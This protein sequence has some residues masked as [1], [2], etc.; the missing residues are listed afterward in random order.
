MIRFVL[1]FFAY[2]GSLLATGAEPFSVEKEIPTLFMVADFSD[3]ALYE[4]EKAKRVS[5]DGCAARIESSV[6]IDDLANDVDRL[7]SE[8]NIG[9]VL[10]KGMWTPTGLA[11]RIRHLRSVARG[12]L[13]FAQDLEWGLSMRHFG[14]VEMPKALCMGAI[15]DDSLL[16]AWADML[17]KT[18]RDVGITCFLGPVADI[19]SNPKNPIIHDRS[20]GDDP[21]VVA[22]KVSVV[23]NALRRHGLI[24]CLKHFPGHGDTSQDSHSSLPVINKTYDQVAKSELIPFRS[25][26]EA[27]ADCV[28]TAHICLPQTLGGMTPASLSPFWCSSTLRNELG[29]QGVVMTDDLIMAGA[30]GSMT[31]AQTA[32]QAVQAGNDLCIVSFDVEKCIDAVIQAV[33]SGRLQRDDIDARAKRVRQ[34][35]ALATPREPSPTLSAQIQLHNLLY[36]KALTSVGEPV[37]FIPSSAILLQVGDAPLCPLMRDLVQAYPGADVESWRRRPRQDE[38]EGLL[39][40]LRAK[41][42]LGGKDSSSYFD[43]IFTSGRTVEDSEPCIHNQTLEVIVVLCDLERSPGCS[44]GITDELLNGVQKITDAG[45]RV[46]YVIFGSPYVLALLPKPVASALV[47]YERTPGSERAVFLALSG[48][49]EPTGVLPVKL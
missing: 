24:V 33:Q 4:K 47:A 35:Q 38:I 17:A 37:R 30:C 36:Q 22:H 10:F 46:R 31:Y 34:L 49:L 15:S 26:I 13:I 40:A 19:N 43:Q 14:A 12:P 23:V 29:F 18:A 27:Q 7:V 2:A 3:T 45:A 16:E 42:A 8:K 48:M 9:G 1:C 21:A 5:I 11:A 39:S 6:S 28:M 44:F 41:A 32:V 20:F 25:G